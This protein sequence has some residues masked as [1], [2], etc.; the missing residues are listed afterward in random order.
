MKGTRI[1]PAT[2]VLSV[3]V[4]T[5]LFLSCAGMPA[6]PRTPTLNDLVI[7][8]DLD[9]I[10]KFYS[11][12]EQLNM[13]DAQGLFPLHYA[14]SRAGSQIAEILIVLG[15]RVD[16]QDR[17]GKTPLRYAIDRR[18]ADTARMLVEKGANPFVADAAGTT[19]AE[20]ALGAGGDM[21]AAVFTPK[22][23][24]SSGLDG[25]TA[26]H[27]AADRLMKDVV[28][29][30]LDMGAQAQ[31]PD[32]A[33]RTPLDLALLYPDRVEAA[34]IAERLILRGANQTF[35]EYSWFVKSVRAMD[36]N[37]I[38]FDDD[39]TPLH[40]AVNLRQKG[41]V[42]FLLDRK[43][44]LNIRNRKG[45][46]PLHRAFALG[47]LE[48]AGLILSAQADPNI[49]DADNR[50]PLHIPMPEQIRLAGTRLLIKHNAD[51][52]LKDNA[53]NTPLHIAVN[54]G[55]PV[56]ILSTLV[57]A[58]APVN[59]ANAAGDTPLIISVR[60]G[61]LVFA[62]PLISNGADLFML[63]LA[64]ESA[65]SLA[66]GA[67]SKAVDAIVTRS[68]VTQ[69]DNLGNSI[70]ST[71]V[72]LKGSGEIISLILSRG[73]D[74][75][76]RNNSGD[77]ALHIAVRENLEEQGR[78]L[79]NAKAD[80]FGTNTKG[81][82]PLVLGLEHA[83]GPLGW[84]FT[85]TTLAARDANGDSPLHIA[86]KRNLGPGILYLVEREPTLMDA[87]NG[88]GET[89]LHA[90]V[91]VDGV[92]A[93]RVLLSL[94]ARTSARDAIGDTPLATSVLWNSNESMKVLVLSGADTDARNF[95]G[96]T[97]LH[98][99]VRRK[100]SVALAYLLDHGSSL[101]PRDS[102]GQTP[103][104]VA[105]ANSAT[106]QARALVTAGSDIEARDLSGKTPLAFA[107]ETGNLELLRLLVGKDADIL[108]TNLADESPLTMSFRKGTTLLRELL[109]PASINRADSE[110]RTPLRILVDKGMSV[111]HIEVALAAGADPG[112]R[113][114]KSETPL[115]EALR[116]KD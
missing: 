71:A 26:L 102:R 64:K 65:L 37:S 55:Y 53:G 41:F 6:A 67:G 84:L 63:N 54:A 46:A 87:T 49:R 7:K 103:L 9:G 104:A 59:A 27:I 20:A 38:R 31:I 100:N 99:A 114:R 69:R 17:A 62:A 112:R 45:E 57:S 10:R 29:K 21:V 52:S 33:G 73:A 24:N 4:L 32:K 60:S 25:R 95:A 30:L 106:D 85:P 110:G 107:V 16:V 40:E 98:Q 8:G 115:L 82:S 12:Q 36:Y 43:V 34:Y 58:G 1:R 18:Y 68:N 2:F 91:R 13:Q 35:P 76:T 80:I 96:E 116:R 94:G 111:E 44:A 42:I 39:N 23:I 81:E 19:S 50:T 72:G 89:P 105:A 88:S 61:N 66:V 101:D 90:A 11:N 51:P 47:W 75:N 97:P 78:I 15:A 3:L 108:A 70:L 79:L 86:S 5:G 14:V 56:D 113:N 83:K 109:S 92:E 93:S 77:S 74:P 48:G 28:F 22:T